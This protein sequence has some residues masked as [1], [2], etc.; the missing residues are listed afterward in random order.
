[1]WLALAHNMT[2]HSRN[3]TANS[4]FSYAEYKKLSDY[5]TKKQRLGV[6]SM[7]R[8]DACTLCLQQAREPVACEEGH[9]YCTECIYADLLSQKKDIKRF[10]A[11]LEEL[12]KEEDAEKIRAAQAARDRVLRDFERNQLGLASRKEPENDKGKG[13]DQT[14]DNETE[15]GDGPGGTKRPASTAFEF[16]LDHAEELARRAEAT[17]LKQLEIEQKEARK[18]KLPSAYWLASETPTAEG[19]D[20]EKAKLKNMKVGT[21]CRASEFGHPLNLKG[22]IPVKFTTQSN[23][24]ST[25]TTSKDSAECICPSCK[26]TLNLGVMFLMR[27]CSHVLCKTCTDTLVAP[28]KQ[29]VVCDSA[30]PKPKDTIQLCREGTGYSGGGRAETKRVGV[31]F[32]G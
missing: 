2:K 21:L 25:S 11:K 23:S 7:K 22:L 16:D 31:S 6:D 17:A 5:G 12:Q 10:K 8:F 9:V 30:L 24:E 13:K 18:S 27:P 32:Q 29:C 28:N 4:V 20:A 14:K 19:K 1:M 26:K 15:N 3:N